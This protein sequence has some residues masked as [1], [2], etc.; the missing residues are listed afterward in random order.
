M[1]SVGSQLKQQLAGRL[2][3]RRSNLKAASQKPHRWF[4]YCSNVLRYTDVCVSLFTPCSYISKVDVLK[5]LVQA[6]YK[7][8]PS[9]DDILE[10]SAVTRL[11]NQLLEA[12]HYQLAVEVSIETGS[13]LGV[14]RTRL[15]SGFFSDQAEA[16]FCVAHRS[17][18]P[19]CLSCQPQLACFICF[20]VY[21]SHNRAISLWHPWSLDPHFIALTC[22][23]KDLAG[24]H[25]RLQ[26]G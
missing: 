15:R 20:F 18:S 11:R 2:I 24:H 17:H 4:V 19:S 14:Q 9:L 23:C 12:E 1:V 7:Y 21:N 16:C 25:I 5:I 26:R 22:R 13:R 8:I 10:T 6:N 3:P